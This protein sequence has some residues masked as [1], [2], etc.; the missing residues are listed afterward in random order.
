MIEKVQFRNFRAYRSLDLELEPFTVLVGPN[1][2]G[3]TTLL[4]GLH[5]LSSTAKQLLGEHGDT[6]VK[7]I[8]KSHGAN[9]SV[10]L[11]VSGHWQGRPGVARLG[12]LERSADVNGRTEWHQHVEI[13]GSWAGKSIPVARDEISHRDPRGDGRFQPSLSVF[14]DA[15]ASTVSLRFD[16]RKLAEASY[17]ENEIP[18]LQGDGTGLAALLAHLKLSSD[19]DFF[20]IEKA[21][22]EIVPAV[23]RIRIERARVHVKDGAF[24]PAMGQ[25]VWGHK[26]VF[27]MKGAKAVP[28]NMVGEG[29]LMALGLLAV[30]LGPAKPHLILLDDI[31]LALHPVAQGRLVDVIRK[32]RVRRPELQVLATSHSPFV[33]NFM[34]PEEVRMAFL[35]EDG[36]A[37]CEKL[38]AHPEYEKWKGLMSPGEFW[39]TVGESWIGNVPASAPHE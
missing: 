10:V 9:E 18:F 20:E 15:L 36:A 1:A 28:A 30:V 11:E 29:T 12:S 21:L 7:E 33:L 38:V 2:S 31:E 8:I 6:E 37:R 13:K 27:D 34:K 3:K 17:S 5:L 35:A 22:V 23:T 39:S 4:E 25:S 26:L 16:S 14:R 32:I 19:E 24:S